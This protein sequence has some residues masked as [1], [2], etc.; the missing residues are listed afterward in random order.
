LRS[1]ASRGRGRA[2]PPDQLGQ[3]LAL[4]LQIPRT[5]REQ[6][7]PGASHQREAETEGQAVAE[8]QPSR[9]DRFADLAHLRS[10]VAGPSVG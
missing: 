1:I 5:D 10:S 2:R 8:R 7:H 4:Q 6:D 9:T 3:V